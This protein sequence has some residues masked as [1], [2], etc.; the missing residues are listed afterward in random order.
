DRRV[1]ARP[2][3]RAGLQLAV[4]VIVDR[5]DLALEV[6]GVAVDDAVARMQAVGGAHGRF[7]V[8]VAEAR[9]GARRG[10]LVVAQRV[11]SRS[12]DGDREARAPQVRDV[13]VLAG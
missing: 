4:A 7:A 8:E 12:P 11:P 2:G 13:L 9:D 3:Q 1:G 6:V 10:D 5:G